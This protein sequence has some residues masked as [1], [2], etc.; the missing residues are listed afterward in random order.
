MFSNGKVKTNLGLLVLRLGIGY[1]MFHHGY[2]KFQMIGTPAADEMAKHFVNFLGIG[3]SASFTLAACGE[4]GGGLLVMLGLFTRLGALGAV[5][6]MATAIYMV[7]WDDPTFMAFGVPKA[8]ELALLYL[9]PFFAIFITGAGA[10]SLDW[11]IAKKSPK[12][13]CLLGQGGV[14]DTDAKA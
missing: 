14:C 6:T 10:I 3:P 9:I 7:H 8:K 13:A 2:E 4:A 11:L 5:I 1:M 12:M